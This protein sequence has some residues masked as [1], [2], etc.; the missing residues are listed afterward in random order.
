MKTSFL[1]I[2]TCFFLGLPTYSVW[3]LEPFD[4][5]GPDF[6]ESSEV[7]P[8]NHFQYEIDVGIANSSNSGAQLHQ[9]D[10]PLLLKYGI[11]ENWELRLAS[12]GFMTQNRQQG[13][14]N[15][16][17]GFKYHSQDR[18]EATGTPSI[19]WIA[20]FQTPIASPYFRTGG[21]LPSFRSVITWNLPNEFALGIMPGVATQANDIGQSYTAGIFGAVLNK[22]LSEKLRVFVELSMPT[23][24][25]VDQNGIVASGDIGAAYLLTF[26][27]QLGFRA[28]L[29]L[30][31]NS[32]KNFGLVELAQRF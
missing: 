21:I 30:N 31:P 5:D 4:T 10:T 29:G 3:A 18:N 24:S 27:T 22:K 14:G 23:I 7:V 26:N 12:D 20:Q 16:A 11:A 6:V 28:G 9:S 13:I 8:K 2:S 32:P 25:K 15:T 1:K 17:F 19:S